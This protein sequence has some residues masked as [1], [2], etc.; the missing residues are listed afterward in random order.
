MNIQIKNNSKEV[1]LATAEIIKLQLIKKPDSLL[2]MAAGHTQKETLEILAEWYKN[3]ELEFDRCKI[4]GLDEWVGIPGDTHGTCFHF[5]YNNLLAPLNVSPDRYSFFDGC[6][7][8]LEAQCINANKLIDKHGSID[9]IILG[10]GMNAHLGFNEPGVDVNLRSHVCDLDNTTKHVGV[11]Y[12]ESAMPITRGITLGLKDIFSAETVVLQ[13]IGEQKA[14]IT[15]QVV[16]GEI[17]NLVPASLARKHTD[18]I[19]LIDKPATS[20]LSPQN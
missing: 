16:E 12:F 17:T 15:K 19:M 7:A 11:K 3:G 5:I 10:V 8:D 18:T 2:C 6:D 1:A 13:I 20:K 14:T 4:I 9:L